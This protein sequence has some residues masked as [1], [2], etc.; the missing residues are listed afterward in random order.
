MNSLEAQNI[1]DWW[2]LKST[3]PHLTKEQKQVYLDRLDK[4][5][6]LVKELNNEEE[7]FKP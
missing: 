7:Y 1:V 2:C 5:I 4:F 6:K 3:S